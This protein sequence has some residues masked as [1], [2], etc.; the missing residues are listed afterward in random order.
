MRQHSRLTAAKVKTCSQPGQYSDGIGLTVRVE[1]AGS[2]PWVQRVTIH[3]ERDNIGLGSFPT[4]CLADAG[5]MVVA[6]QPAV[7]QGR[8]SLVEKQECAVVGEEG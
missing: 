2:K 6:S 3:G 1:A 5:E 4:V 8:D 7:K